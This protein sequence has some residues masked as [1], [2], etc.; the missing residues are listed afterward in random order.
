MNVYHKLSIL[1]C[2]LVYHLLR[3]KLLIFTPLKLK[4]YPQ[5]IEVQKSKVAEY[6]VLM[7]L[8]VYDIT[9]LVVIV[10]KETNASIISHSSRQFSSLFR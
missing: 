4:I 9:A 3:L 8:L 7:A 1:K 6:Y 10:Y 2:E 5:V